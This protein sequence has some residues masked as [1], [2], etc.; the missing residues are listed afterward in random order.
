MD[1]DVLY[2]PSG[3][4][5]RA[6]RG[7][8]AKIGRL[9]D[10]TPPQDSTPFEEHGARAILWTRP[11]LPPE[12]GMPYLHGYDKRA[13][14][15][16]AS[17]IVL[18]VG[19]W[20]HIAM[21]DALESYTF[22]DAGVWRLEFHGGHSDKD[23]A[24]S[25]CSVYEA[26]A[27][28]KMISRFLEGWFY[29]PMVRAL[30]TLGYNFHVKEGYFFPEGK[31][32]LKHWREKMLEGLAISHAVEMNGNPFLRRMIKATYTRAIGLMGSQTFSHDTL[33]RPDW[34]SMIIDEASARILFN[35]DKIGRLSLETGQPLAEPLAVYDDCL[36]YPS[37]SP[38]PYA[39]T[40]I[41]TAGGNLS[42]KF[43][44]KGSY[45]LTAPGCRELFGAAPSKFI[46]S[47]EKF[48][49]GGAH[50]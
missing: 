3:T 35:V 17:D 38:D 8:A 10:L 41:L 11:I 18:G 19:D 1:G 30:K 43:V 40:P 50:E 28:G 44:Y 26:H 15:L 24:L 4:G 5:L 20:E 6:I 47:I 33:Y 2:K 9:A 48:R 25:R 12:E 32:I 16:H 39:A 31:A 34:R 22:K 27:K 37:F 36:Y 7:Y 29:S 49:I 42:A 46:R 14:Y 21:E 23:I 45:D 13:S